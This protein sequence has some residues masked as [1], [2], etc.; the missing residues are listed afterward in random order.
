MRDI[1]YRNFQ[2]GNALVQ[3]SKKKKSLQTLSR[4]GLTPQLLANQDF[5]ELIIIIIWLISGS[6][7]TADFAEEVWN[8]A[9][10]AQC[11]KGF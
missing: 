11:P 6:F 1:S 5:V 3:I 2:D 10:V 9:H 7:S 8:Q 4:L